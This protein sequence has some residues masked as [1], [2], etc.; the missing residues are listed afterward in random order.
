LAYLRIR[1]VLRYLNL[2]IPFSVVRILKNI[3]KL[4]Q[5]KS[6]EKSKNLLIISLYSETDFTI[7]PNI[8]STLKNNNLI[9][10]ENTTL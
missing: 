9:V 3:L 10:C 4:K 2:L 6:K 1:Y 5:M 7:F 8:L